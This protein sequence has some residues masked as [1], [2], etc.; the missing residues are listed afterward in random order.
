MHT[1]Y[2]SHFL[3]LNG[4]FISGYRPCLYPVHPGMW[5]KHKLTVDRV[6][7]PPPPLLF[8]FL[9][10]PQFKAWLSKLQPIVSS[11]DVDLQQFPVTWNHLIAPGALPAAGGSR[12]A[13]A[14]QAKPPIPYCFYASK[15]NGA[16]GSWPET[17]RTQTYYQNIW[18]YT[19]N[20]R[21][22]F[23]DWIYK[24]RLIFKFVLSLHHL[25]SSHTHFP[26][27]K[28]HFPFFLTVI[29]AASKALHP[30][31][32]VIVTPAWSHSQRISPRFPPH[33]VPAQTLCNTTR[34]LFASERGGGMQRHDLSGLREDQSRGEHLPTWA[35]MSDS[36]PLN[37]IVGGRQTFSC[38][39]ITVITAPPYRWFNPLYIVCS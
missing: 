8:F 4:G 37:C 5:W 21:Y 1:V 25:L 23:T 24:T 32:W 16:R 26:H 13:S 38:V 36:C 30:V 15:V 7:I 17:L 33:I 12:R 9:S 29:Q 28:D 19:W 34:R 2:V 22:K 35:D 27:L 31:L 39:F 18:N 20:L 10:E 14:G 11:V 3:W 6:Y